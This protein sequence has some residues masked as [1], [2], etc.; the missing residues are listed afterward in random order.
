MRGSSGGRD[1]CSATVVVAATALSD[2]RIWFGVG[3]VFR[4]L[5]ERK[6]VPKVVCREGI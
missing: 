3:I 4:K 6:R 5:Q 1:R 2:F